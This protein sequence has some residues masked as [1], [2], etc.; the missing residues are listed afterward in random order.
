MII[1]KF[2]ILLAIFVIQSNESEQKNEEKKEMIIFNIFAS[3]WFEKNKSK[4][5]SVT[6]HELLLELKHELNTK[7][8]TEINESIFKEVFAFVLNEKKSLIFKILALKWFKANKKD[9]IKK[10]DHQLKDEFLAKM[11]LK[12]D[13]KTL[14]E[15]LVLVL[16]EKK[17]TISRLL[18]IKW[19]EKNKND[20]VLKT[21]HELKT[22]L[23]KELVSQMKLELDHNTFN[24][25]F[26]LILNEKNKIVPSYLALKWLEKN[27]NSLILMSDREVKSKLKH[28]LNSNMNVEIDQIGFEETIR[29]VL[30]EKI[31]QFSKSVALK[32]FEQNK[33]DLI[34]LTD[35]EVKLKLKH[36]LT[37]KMNI[38][39]DPK[40]INEAL[41]LILKEKKKT[42]TKKIKDIHSKNK[43]YKTRF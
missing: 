37:S 24:E 33:N 19:F 25:I 41:S 5:I 27:K 21:D 20:L 31:R 43:I 8:K 1:I 28:E 32:W 40:T 39:I 38:K 9:L 35:H 42:I 22:K 18:A 23:K 26:N 13:S 11:K 2:C 4:L 17:R 15:A 29:L 14:N 10:T 36:E 3:K 16:K 30:N 34:L 12:I 6:N 7:M